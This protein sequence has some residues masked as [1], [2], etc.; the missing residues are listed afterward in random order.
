VKERSSRL[1]S[2]DVLRGIAVLAVLLNHL[3]HSARLTAPGGAGEMVRSVF[4]AWVEHV[5]RYGQFGVHLFLVIS[6]FCI[7]MQWARRAAQAGLDTEVRF[8]AFWRR[9]LRRLYPPYFVALLFSLA[10]LYVF[11][12]VLGHQRG[13]AASFGYPS[14]RTFVVDVVVLV[15]LFQNVNDASH[16]VGN[17]PFWSLALEEQLYLLY[18][19]L[20]WLRRRQGWTRALLVAVAATLLWRA[21]GVAFDLPRHVPGWILIG[22]SRWLEWVLGALAV[23]AHLGLV[24]FPRWARSYAV[25]SLFLAIAIALNAP[26]VLQHP[27]ALLVSDASF[28]LAFFVLLNAT[29]HSEPKLHGSAGARLLAWVGTWSYS[30][31]LI[32]EPSL[33]AAKQVALRLGAGTAGVVLFRFGGTLIAAYAFHRLVERRFIDARAKAS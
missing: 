21:L 26:P 33:V 22:P 18:F 32:Q 27:V 25:G 9:R 30:L 6:G 7:H 29:C 15:L 14:L 31:Y 11:F 1:V 8:G 24:R 2:I 28:G 5:T 16:R 3:P 17:G 12:H 13:L 19:P 23:E 10:G 4:P 20:L